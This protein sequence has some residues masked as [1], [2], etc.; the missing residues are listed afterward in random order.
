MAIYTYSL[1][2]GTL[3][4]VK[5]SGVLEGALSEL[6]EVEY[7]EFQLRCVWNIKVQDK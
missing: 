7:L 2:S 3:N 1:N 5:P 6:S 4:R